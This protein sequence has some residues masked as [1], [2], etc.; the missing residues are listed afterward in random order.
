MRRV[1]VTVSQCQRLAANLLRLHV[2]FDHVCPEP[3]LWDGVPIIQ[4]QAGLLFDDLLWCVHHGSF[5]MSR[6]FAL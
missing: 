1:D 5:V 2:A 3:E 4:R 6:V